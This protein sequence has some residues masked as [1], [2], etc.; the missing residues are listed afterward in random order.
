MSPEKS[1]NQIKGP[2][3]YDMKAGLTQIIFALKTIQY[4]HLSPVLTPILLIN[5][6]EEIGSRESGPTVKRLAKIAQRAY[7]LEPPLGFEGKLKTRRKGLGRFTITVRGEA[8]HAGL[9]PE[10]GASAIV[11]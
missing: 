3:V 10:K 5:A 1:K 7:V 9:D 8:A 11:E 4:L 6:D 2:G